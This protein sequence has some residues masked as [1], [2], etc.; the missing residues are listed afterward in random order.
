MGK[1][2]AGGAIAQI[3]VTLPHSLGQPIGGLCDAPHGESVAAC[4]AKVIEF[5]YLLNIEKFAEI[6]QILDPSINVPDKKQKAEK[7]AGLVE[8]FLND[9]DLTVRFSDYEMSENDIERASRIAITGYY[10]D[11]NCHPKKVTEEDIKKLYRDCL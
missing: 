11:I 8:K 5:S 2:L 6:A 3:G 4:M 10:F 9:I 1:S 7:C